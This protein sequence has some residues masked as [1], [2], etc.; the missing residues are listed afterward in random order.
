[1][2]ILIDLI[3]GVFALTAIAA[4]IGHKIDQKI[5]TS[6]IF[7]IILGIIAII[8]GLTRLVLKANKLAEKEDKK[9]N[10]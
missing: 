10:E 2:A 5:G 7:A 9:A 8:F 4:T 3:F 1:M 6:P